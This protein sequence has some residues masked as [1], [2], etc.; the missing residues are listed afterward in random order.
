MTQTESASL[1]KFA[2][3]YTIPCEHRVSVGVTATAA[4]E[5]IARVRE[6]FD[7]GTVRDDTAEMPLLE[8]RHVE[9]PPGIEGHVAKRL[10]IGAT[11]VAGEFEIHPSVG[12]RLQRRFAHRQA[13]IAAPVTLATIDPQHLAVEALDA[14]C[15]LIQARLGVTSGD[16]AGI[17]F[18]G[19]DV[20]AILAAYVRSEIAVQTGETPRHLDPLS[21]RREVP[22]AELDRP[23]VLSVNLRSCGNIDMGQDPDRPLFGVPTMPAH[24]VGSLRAAGQACRAYIERHG[25][26]SSQWVGGWV[27]DGASAIVAHVSYNGRVWFPNET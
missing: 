26:G 13:P 25:L 10:V 23:Q 6:A 3:S 21:Y 24:R 1:Q 9:H 20:E 12:E 8:D 18:S 19:S 14:A 7:A 16:L 11:R 4:D 2:V 27:R 17:F 15:A 5:A 22:A